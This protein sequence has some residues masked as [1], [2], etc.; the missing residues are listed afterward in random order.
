VIVV[1]GEGLVDAY[2]DGDRPPAAG[3]ARHSPADV[4]A[5]VGAGSGPKAV[6]SRA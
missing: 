4:L 1:V 3:S 6:R 5:F 2:P